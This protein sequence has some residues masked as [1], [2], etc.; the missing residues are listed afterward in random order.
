MYNITTKLSKRMQIQ[1]YEQIDIYKYLR[2]FVYKRK[3]KLKSL[4]KQVQ[5]FS[6]LTRIEMLRLGGRTIAFKIQI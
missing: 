3:I 6:L 2:F 5:G 4:L 1:K